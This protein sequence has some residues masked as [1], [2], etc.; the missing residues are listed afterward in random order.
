MSSSDDEEEEN[1][2]ASTSDSSDEQNEWHLDEDLEGDVLPLLNITSFGWTE[3]GRCSS[4]A[5]KIFPGAAV[6]SSIVSTTISSA[7]TKSVEETEFTALPDKKTSGTTPLTQICPRPIASLRAAPIPITENDRDKSSFGNKR[8]SRKQSQPSHLSNRTNALENNSKDR[9]PLFVC[10]DISAGSRHSLIVMIDCQ[11]YDFIPGQYDED[12]NPIKHPKPTKKLYTVALCE[13]PGNQEPVEVPWNWK[14]RSLRQILAGHGN[15]FIV[16]KKG[17]VYSNFGVLGH[18]VCESIEIPRRIRALEMLKVKQIATGAAHT[19]KKQPM[20]LV[21]DGSPSRALF[22]WGRNH[23][24]QLGQGFES[25]MEMTPRAID[26]SKLSLHG[27]RFQIEVSCG[28]HHCI[29][30]LTIKKAK[31]NLSVIYAWGD[32]SKGQLG[33]GDASSR[34]RPQENRWLT[35]FCASRKMYIKK[36]A[37]GAINTAV[38]AAKCSLQL[39]VTNYLF[40][41]SGQV[42]AW[43]A[44]DY[45]QLGSG[46]VWDDATPRFVVNLDH[47]VDISAG[48]RHS[49]A[50]GENP[51]DVYAWGYNGYG[52]LGL[53]DVNIRLGATKVSAFRFSRVRAISCGDRHTLVMMSHKPIRYKE[54]LTLKPYF[55]ILQ[56]GGANNMALLKK[57]KWTMSKKGLDS[58]AL[59]KADSIIPNQAGSEDK[60]VKNLTFDKGLR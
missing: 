55:K 31:G 32:E 54:D 60:E 22:S 34:M 39:V 20:A 57:L 38:T 27:I 12:G 5:P 37:A 43:G 41:G 40:E 7:V 47:V 8:R 17:V 9:K 19:G 25:V 11:N 59:D 16:T 15:S 49:M 56:S 1:D 53:G 13:E 36:I 58:N 30:L 24:G 52:E 6:T 33:S 2:I 50:I 46:F 29:A 14:L 23:K 4:Y 51:S 26:F 21:E 18:G 42:V 44:G 10:K 48:L 28:Q 35:K 3:D 45:G